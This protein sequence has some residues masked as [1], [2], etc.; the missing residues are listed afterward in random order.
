MNEFL[1]GVYIGGALGCFMLLYITFS[2]DPE[3]HVGGW[4][5]VGILLIIPLVWFLFFGYIRYEIRRRQQEEAHCAN[6]LRKFYS[7]LP[8]AADIERKINDG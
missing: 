5:K 4:W 7:Q 8:T 2:G 6:L 3:K 1:F